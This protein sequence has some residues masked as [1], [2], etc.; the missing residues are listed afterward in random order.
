M[1]VG[2]QQVSLMGGGQLAKGRDELSNGLSKT[3]CS[4]QVRAHIA[5]RSA[6]SVFY[7][8]ICTHFLKHT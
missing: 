5:T 8:S 6:L 2:T 7:S 3:K 4:S 1:K